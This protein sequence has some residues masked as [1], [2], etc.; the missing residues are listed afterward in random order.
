MTARKKAPA[1]RKTV[2]Y[3]TI[4]ATIR[5]VRLAKAGDAGRKTYGQLACAER[6]GISRTQWADLEADRHA[7][8]LQLIARAAA[9]LRLTPT[10]LLRE[11]ARRHL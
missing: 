1:I 6:A 11:H 5:A 8:S 3:A 10:G 9:A 4:G 2:D 7:P